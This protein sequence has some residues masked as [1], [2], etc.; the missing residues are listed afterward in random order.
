MELITLIHV[1]NWRCV[2][3]YVC[4]PGPVSAG[5][6]RERGDVLLLLQRGE[7]VARGRKLLPGQ[8]RPPVEHP[9]HSRDGESNRHSSTPRG[10]CFVCLGRT[11]C[12]PDTCLFSPL[13]FSGEKQKSAVAE[14]ASRLWNLLDWFDWPNK[15]KCLGVERWVHLL[16][17]PIVR[18]PPHYPNAGVF[19]V[20]VF[21][22]FF[23]V[24]NKW[25]NK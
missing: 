22:C 17:V 15:G 24:L 6:E 8:A 5:L 9:G 14:D 2:V 25:I 13:Y 20:F 21:L 23:P 12:C 7:D 10:F 1:I 11:S 19:F 18:A 4:S 16:W 3:S